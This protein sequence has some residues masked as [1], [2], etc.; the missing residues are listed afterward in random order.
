MPRR[1]RTFRPAHR[2]RGGEGGLSAERLEG[3]IVLAAA[4]GWERASRT[5]SIVGSE[6]ND[7]AQVRQ[8]GGNLVVSLNSATGRLSRTVPAAQ[9]SQ[10]VFTGLAGNDTFRPGA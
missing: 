10:V 4:I 6:G 9:V 2:S 3:R 5:V 8:Q 7:S 1:G